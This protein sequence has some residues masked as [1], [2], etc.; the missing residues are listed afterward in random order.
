M[1]QK[2]GNNHCSPSWHD[3]PCKGFGSEQA[4]KHIKEQPGALRAAKDPGE[5]AANWVVLKG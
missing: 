1:G 5:T 4:T 3:W 2:G